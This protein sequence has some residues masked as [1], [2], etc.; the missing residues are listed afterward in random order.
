MKDVRERAAT[1]LQPLLAGGV[2]PVVTGLSVRLR[3]EF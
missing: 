3:M 1:V 2:T